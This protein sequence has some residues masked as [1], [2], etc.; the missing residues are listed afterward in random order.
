MNEQIICYYEDLDN[1]K[2]IYCGM[3]K[4]GI[5]LICEDVCKDCPF[6][7]LGSNANGLREALDRDFDE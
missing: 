6:S 1:S 2:P 4:M 7:P 5:E 3:Q